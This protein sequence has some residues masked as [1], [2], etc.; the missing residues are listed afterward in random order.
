MGDINRSSQ[1]FKVKSC[2]TVNL[3]RASFSWNL[4]RVVWFMIFYSNFGLTDRNPPQKWHMQ[5]SLLFANVSPKLVKRRNF[6]KKYYVWGNLLGSSSINGRWWKMTY[7]HWK[8]CWSVLYHLWIA[9]ILG[10]HHENWLFLVF[11][12]QICALFCIFYCISPQNTL[13]PQFFNSLAAV[14]IEI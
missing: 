4:W 1:F 9:T 5:M 14:T 8:M 6:C 10:K 12:R 7:G 2:P 11:L 13:K 3:F